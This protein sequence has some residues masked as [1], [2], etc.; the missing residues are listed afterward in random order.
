MIE[1]IVEE[2]NQGMI[3]DSHRNTPTEYS[4]T[5]PVEVVECSQS[6]GQASRDD[7][8]DGFLKSFSN[9]PENIR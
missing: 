5:P 9:D 3:S 7:S 1:E 2:E 8:A 4:V 6:N